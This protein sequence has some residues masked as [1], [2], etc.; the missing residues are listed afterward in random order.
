MMKSILSV[1][2]PIH[3][4]HQKLN[5]LKQWI[6]E[7]SSL[8][9]QVVLVD[10][11]TSEESSREIKNLIGLYP[12]L[13]IKMTTGKFESPGKARNAGLQEATGAWVIFA[14]SDDILYLEPI[15]SCLLESKPKTIEVFQFRKLDFRST[16]ILKPLSTTASETDLVFDLGIWRMAFPASFLANHQFTEI[17]MGEDILYFL[18]VF[19]S[20]PEIHF[21]SIHGYDYMVG[22]GTQLTADN[23]AIKELTLLLGE[24]AHRIEI[25][26]TASILARL[27][28]FKNTL[29][30]A[31]HLGVSKSYKYAWLSL[32]MFFSSSFSDKQKFIKIIGKYFKS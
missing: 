26:K 16:K 8:E 23:G 12:K 7:I 10:D 30:V 18:D 1:V 25:F 27:I 9:V 14:D 32:L 21:N 2:V 6:S 29:S 22:S 31:K 3:D 17:R 11:F 20:N 13:N 19:E 24:L 15:L 5:H 28:F 4:M